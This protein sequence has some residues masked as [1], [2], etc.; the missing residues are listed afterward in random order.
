MDIKRDWQEVCKNV[1][2]CLQVFMRT[3]FSV[4]LFLKFLKRTHNSKKLKDEMHEC[5]TRENDNLILPVNLLI[6]TVL[7]HLKSLILR[8]EK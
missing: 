1:T 2:S 8:I 7:F 3:L 5:R 4:S 6:E